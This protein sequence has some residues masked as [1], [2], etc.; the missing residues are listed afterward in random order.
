MGVLSFF[1]GK[2]KRSKRSKKVNKNTKKPNITLIRKCIRLKIKVTRKI[3]KRRVYKSTKTL[4]K[5]LAKKLR[6]LKKVKRNKRYRFGVNSKFK[7]D[8]SLNVKGQ[9]IILTPDTLKEELLGK[10]KKI[11][12]IDR[13]NIDTVKE[14]IVKIIPKTMDINSLTL[15]QTIDIATRLTTQVTMFN[16][17]VKFEK[18][19]EINGSN[20]KKKLNDL[21][22][23]L[24]SADRYSTVNKNT[25]FGKDIFHNRNFKDE[26]VKNATVYLPFTLIGLAFAVV[27]E[28]FNVLFSPS[29]ERFE[30]FIEYQ[31]KDSFIPKSRFNNALKTDYINRFVKKINNILSRYIEYYTPTYSSMRRD[32]VKIRKEGCLAHI[33][34]EFTTFENRIKENNNEQYLNWINDFFKNDKSSYVV[35][36]PIPERIYTRGQNPT[37]I[38]NVYGYNTFKDRAFLSAEEVDKRR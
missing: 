34:D 4:K 11:F 14:Q 16:T 9:K 25:K 26:V 10:R 33:R 22:T 17:N 37:Y 21:Y 35:A 3:G 12:L 36:I 18:K 13:I 5:L 20:L 32:D 8:L 23:I 27:G 30:S 1:F 7:P 19:I 15:Q 6:N 38:K 29:Q 31:I 2:K 28:V 24:Y